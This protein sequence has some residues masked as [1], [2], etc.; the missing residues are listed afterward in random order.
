MNKN[1]DREDM[2]QIK[3]S[4]GV[5]TNDSDC[6][7]VTRELS[8]DPTR[9][10]QRG[11]L[12]VRA[13]SKEPRPTY[14]GLWEISR[15]EVGMDVYLSDQIEHFQRLLKDKFEGIEKLKT[16]YNFDCFFYVKVTTEYGQFGFNLDESELAF[17]R[18]IANRFTF[19]SLCV[20]NL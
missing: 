7:I 15:V 13:S 3:V 19:S 5:I 10:H 2:T 12:V 20:D 16:H 8:L 17:I 9:C 1:D 11:E 18:R 4:F 14:S 6:N